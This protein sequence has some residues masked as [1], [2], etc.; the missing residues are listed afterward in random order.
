ML[1][2][3]DVSKVFNPH[4]VNELVLYHG[5]NLRVKKGEFVT[6]IGSNGSG[7]STLFNM[8]CGTMAP[9]KGDIKLDGKS[10]TNVLEYQRLKRFARIYQDPQ[11]GTA[12]SLTILENLV[13]ADNKNKPFNLTKAVDRSKKD[14]FIGLLQMLNLGLED[15]LDQQ[16]ETLSGGQR[17]ALALLMATIGKP[18]LILLDEHTAALD[19]QT[20]EKI[21]MLTEKIVKIQE[22]T[23]LMITHNLKQALTLGDRLLMFHKGKIVLD[24]DAQTKSKLTVQNLIEHFTRLNMTEEL[25]D[26]MVFSL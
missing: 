18:E 9:D 4:S 1:E 23:A 24:L 19:P 21:A 17:Q 7:K 13:I 11:I 6:I 3:I 16:V 15:K 25:S 12:P 2:L 14:Y 10:I 22:A 5:L 20:S 8:I 26:D